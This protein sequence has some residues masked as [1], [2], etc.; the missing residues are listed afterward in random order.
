MQI[1]EN[2]MRDVKV[3]DHLC[4]IYETPEEQLG[5]A[6]PYLKQGLEQGERALY[7]TDETSVETICDAMRCRGMDVRAALSSGALQFATSRDAYLQRGY[8]TP[9]GM[10]AHLG[11]HEQRAKADGFSALRVT[12]EMTWA[13]GNEEGVERILEYESLVNRFFQE[14]ESSAICQYN[15]Q[16]FPAK[17][18]RGI[19]HTHPLVI[20]GSVVCRNHFY[21]PPEEYLAQCGPQR[22]EAEV[23]RMLNQLVS[24][25][26]SEVE[27]TRA[28][29][30]L[31][32]SEKLAATARLAATIAHEINN[33][34]EAVTNMLYLLRNDDAIQGQSRDFVSKMEEQVKR[35]G[36]I[37]RQTLG[38]YRESST[39]GPVKI[40]EL[41]PDVELLFRTRLQI[42]G[43]RLIA[44]VDKKAVVLGIPGEVR[45]VLANLVAN[46]I[47]A[48]G[49]GSTV[50]ITGNNIDDS[51]VV[52]V[53][54]NGHGIPE[55]VRP[56]IFEPFFTTKRKS[57][58]G[59]GLWIVRDLVQRQK[60][61]LTV[62][63]SAEG[64]RFSMTLPRFAAQPALKASLSHSA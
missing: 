8:F 62:E 15:R 61:T 6:I 20:H 26:R 34:L 10:I 17:I 53:E 4:L 2:A 13:L 45:Q 7:V 40:R 52:T 63:S 55:E 18:I 58:T 56:H 11:D 19:I 30:A 27:R 44:D 24:L 35:I 57:G 64:T 41:I 22:A 3:H 54:D 12:A 38:F 31:R 39:P 9:E 49:H 14:R 42:C 37:T 46:A 36:M 33:P 43:V 47:D 50:R 28:E 48:S 32:E 5:A 1:L 59:L 16:R 21:I 29:Q 60:G 25:E 23:A 51:V